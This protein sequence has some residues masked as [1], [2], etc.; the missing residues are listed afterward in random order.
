M[1]LAIGGGGEGGKMSSAIYA[2]KNTDQKW[3]WLG[4]MPFECS[5]ADTLQLSVGKLLLVDGVS[6]RVLGITA[7]GKTCCYE[8]YFTTSICRSDNIQSKK[9]HTF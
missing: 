2:F 7:E 1:L 8:M 5:Y 9:V 4:D 6:R 3:H